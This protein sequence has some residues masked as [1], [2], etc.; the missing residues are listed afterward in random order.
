MIEHSFHGIISS[1]KKGESVTHVSGTIC[2]LGVGSLTLVISIVYAVF[3]A[4]AS[5]RSF[6]YIRYN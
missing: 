6:R 5:A 4:S 3:A 2:F 1:A